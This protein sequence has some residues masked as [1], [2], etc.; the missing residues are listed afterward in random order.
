MHQ[1]V[2]LSEVVEG[3]KLAPGKKI[4]DCTLGCGG[5]AE[6]VLERIA[7][8]GMLIGIDQDEESLKLAGNRLKKFEKKLLLIQ[9]NFR[10]LKSILK[11]VNVGEVDGILFDLGLSSFQLE[12]EKRGFSINK[13]GPV[14]MRMDLR[15][16]TNAAHLINSLDQKEIARILREF[17]E[18]RYSGRIARA[19]VSERPITSTH[20]LALAVSKVVPAKYRHGRIHPATRTFQA[21]RIAVNNELEV[22][23]IVLKDVTGLVKKNG[24]ICV[25]SFHSLE[26]RIVKQTF[27]E[28]KNNGLLKIITKKPLTPEEK[29]IFSN[30]RSR[31]AKLRVAERI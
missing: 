20:S 19:I 21:L 5:H 1:P 16:N 17:G 13:D 30:P 6:A 28:H 15:Q 2:L 18:E 4:V 24:R 3:L 23:K 27:R 25:I 12:E 22:L 8:E 26:D 11:K 9:D 10:N 14:D 7:P 29:E 31:S